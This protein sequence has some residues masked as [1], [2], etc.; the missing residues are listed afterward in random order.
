MRKKYHLASSQETVCAEV[1]LEEGQRE[2]SGLT[3]SL[4]LILCPLKGHRR[5]EQLWMGCFIYFNVWWVDLGWLLDP[6]PASLLLP[7]L[8]KT[9]EKI[10]WNSSWVMIRTGRSLTN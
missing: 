6:H 7:L 9:R 2:G 1:Q 10:R 5:G 8:Y 4:F 3:E